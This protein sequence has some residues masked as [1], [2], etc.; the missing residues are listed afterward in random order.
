MV[1]SSRG[2]NYVLG[3]DIGISSVGWGIINADSGGIIDGGVR[4]FEEAAKNANEDRRS[5]RGSR[6]LKRRRTHRLDRFRELLKS[7][8]LSLD[9]IGKFNPY[10][11]RKTALYE[12]V[13]EGKFVAALY[14]LVKRRG[15]VL[16][17]PEEEIVGT[18]ELSTKEQLS[19]NKKMLETKY[20]CEIQMERLGVPA[21]KVRD[22]QNR[23]RTVD[24]IREA[25][26]I[27]EEQK[28]YNDKISVEFSDNVIDLLGKRR[29]Y[30]EGP[31]S[32]KSPT[33][34]GSFFIDEQGRLQEVSLINK[35]RGKCTY[36]PEELRIAKMSFTADLF[37]LLNG[38]LNKIQIDGEY[39]TTEDKKYLVDTFI[40]KGKNITLNQILK[41][42][43]ASSDAVVSGY[44]IDMK[45][46]KPTFTEF[47][48]YKIIYKTV[49][50]NNL[51]EAL[52]KQI[53][54]LDEIVNV[55]SAEKSYDR[56][57]LQLGNILTMYSDETK[58]EII[59]SFIE[60]T[61]F[62]GYHALSKKA[63][64]LIMQQLWE[65]N[66]NQMELYSE[67]KLEEKRLENLTSSK[68]IKFDDEA[69]L[70]TVAKRAH[71]ETIKIVN[72]ARKKYGEFATIVVETA[73][74]KNSDDKRLQ[75]SK[76]Q[77]NIGKFEKRMA[78][79]LNVKTLAELRLNGKQHLALK[80]WD[81]QDG[82]CIYSGIG[83]SVNQIVDDFTQFEIDHI[84]PISISF[85]DSQANKVLCYQGENQKKGQKTPFQYFVSGKS[86]GSFEQF[87][88]EVLNLHKAR[89]ITNKKKDYLLE[90]RDVQNNEELQKQFINR[91]LVDT[92]YAMRSFSMT[93]RTYF[94][95]NEID[96]TVLSIR[97][98]FTSA[99]RRRMRMNKD[100]DESHAHHGIDALIVATIGKMP[101]FGFFKDFDMNEQGVVFEKSTGEILEEDEFFDH[102][103]MKFIREIRNYESKLKYS[104]KVDRK[105]NRA[106]SNQTIYGT[107]EK[108]GEK[109]YLGK[110][111]NIYE[112][113][114][115]GVKPLLNRINKNPGSFLIAEH[116]PDLFEHIQKI[117]EEYPN[118][119]NPFKAYYD[120]HGYIKKDG[121]VPV[122]VLRYRDRKLGV[123]MKITGN[124]P[125]AKNDVVLL[126]IK[127][128]RVDLYR[129]SE[130]KYKYLG[131][132]YHWF[133]K[134]GNQYVLDMKKYENEKKQKYKNIDD[135]F[136]FQLSL[137]KNDMFSFEKGGEL[138]KRIF[139]G[140]AMPRNN[141]V[142]VDYVYK[143]KKKRKEGFISPSTISD[144]IKYN[145]DILGN[146]YGLEKEM[147]KSTLQM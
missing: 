65:T 9:G 48:G 79:L 43:E 101:I 136:E 64:T 105:P 11:C 38:D 93:L 33:P 117:I 67:L 13:S 88:V 142:E 14:H 114:K 62:K 83:I 2:K 147:F 82:K 112:L 24:Y 119:D 36:Y 55:L 95:V 40:M 100:R 124:Y 99:L 61:D 104:H 6:R 70:S 29:E 129:N 19:R 75:Y 54:V 102:Q 12:E 108:D 92:Q 113:D 116:N 131:V 132:P 120:E 110:S 16:D 8:G 10:E 34:Y 107:R 46:D 91:N 71:R 73:R 41:Y 109:Y 45:T 81:Q 80:L 57:K 128:L 59:N 5:F 66:K 123:H 97:G 127:G 63:M 37:N 78:T 133:K 126:S 77:R 26:A 68:E 85:D 50:E 90:I 60:N 94:K 4:L 47:K 1:D 122:K 27:L 144:V 115:N 69:I 146:K 51:P 3:L 42:K 111:G 138:V 84:I 31:G 56:R 52:L 125:K 7:N 96:T 39:L 139:R 134:E 137:Y 15:V 30:F 35:M 44:R 118:A 106:M 17:A 103:F 141:I 72:A 76:F 25:K 74:E 121:K 20:I 49:K 23:F 145:V 130:G 58:E 53:D 32:A 98:A 28:K 140:D 22:H 86:N 87:K 21:G 89:K 135:T 18:N 143:M